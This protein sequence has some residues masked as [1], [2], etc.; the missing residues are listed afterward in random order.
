MNIITLENA[1]GYKTEKTLETALKRMGLDEYGCRYIV[2]RK[3]DGD[4]TAVFLVTEY[5]NK[6]GGYVGF[7][8][9]KGFTSV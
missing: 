4:W 3:P 9:Q 8:A 1:K 7:A 6:H 5:L 2:C